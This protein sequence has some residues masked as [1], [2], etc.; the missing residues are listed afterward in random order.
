MKKK[1]LI[2][3]LFVCSFFLHF[4]SHSYG[5]GFSK[6]VSLMISKI[7]K[8]YVGVELLGSMG[9]ITYGRYLTP[10]KRVKQSLYFGLNPL[11]IAFLPGLT[12][13]Y[14]IETPLKNNI[15]YYA[16][17]G[18]ELGALV[19]PAILLDSKNKK[20]TGT[21]ADASIQ[22]NLGISYTVNRCVI[23]PL[24]LRYTENRDLLYAE[25]ESLTYYRFIALG[26]NFKYKF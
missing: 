26:M 6:I 17:I 10:Q 8:N 22:L 19:F 13:G 4:R 23:T 3:L 18:T 2:Q 7:R 5:Q 1:I 16:E 15:N 12:I 24:F 9:R 20:I 11:I 21:L 14:R 25:G